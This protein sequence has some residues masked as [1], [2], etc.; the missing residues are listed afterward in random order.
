MNLL[1][2]KQERRLAEE[3][4]RKVEADPARFGVTGSL[5]LGIDAERMSKLKA[6]IEER[7]NARMDRDGP[8]LVVNTE[9]AVD[10]QMIVKGEREE[11]DMVMTK[12]CRPIP[13]DISSRW[14]WIARRKE[15]EAVLHE[16]YKV[17]EDS[18]WG[19]S[20]VELRQLLVEKISLAKGSGEGKREGDV[21]TRRRTSK[22]KKRDLLDNPAEGK[23]PALPRM[24]EGPAKP[25]NKL[26]MTGSNTIQ[27][28]CLCCGSKF[29]IRISLEGINLSQR[30]RCQRY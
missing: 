20:L 30:E 16:K 22:L 19:M 13:T 29:E 9:V 6:E 26:G 10:Q 8:G 4:R 2:A 7:E 28:F 24:P 27:A 23:P 14:P 18:L 3:S 5:S 25:I 1:I 17:E 12:E 21:P 15:L 11:G